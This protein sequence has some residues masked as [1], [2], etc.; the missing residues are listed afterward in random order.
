[1]YVDELELRV[2]VDEVKGS[3]KVMVIVR[4][5]LYKPYG[6]VFDL[7]PS[8]EKRLLGF[9]LKSTVLM[10]S[11]VTESISSTSHCFVSVNCI[12]QS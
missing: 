10:K 12:A 8:A 6:R 1:M 5:N 9:E 11:L 7:I 3:V 2:I 4:V